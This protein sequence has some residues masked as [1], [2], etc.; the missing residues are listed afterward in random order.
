MAASAD[1]ISR[2]RALLSIATPLGKDALIPVSLR[3][4]EAISLPF[5]FTVEMVSE[6]E[7][8]DP[9]ALLAK[10][11]CVTLR[12]R[13]DAEGDRLLRHFSGLVRRFAATGVKGRTLWGYRA[14]IVPALWFLS[15]TE[16]CRVFQNMTALD[17]IEQVLGDGGV[18]E[19]DIRVQGE[20]PTREYTV[21]YNETDLAFVTRLMEEEGYF[22]FFE[23]KDNAHTLVIAN[24]NTAFA[25]IPESAMR[26]SPDGQGLVDCLTA[27]EPAKS[28]AHGRVRLT[29]YDHTAPGKALDASTSTVFS[30]AQA[31]RR[32]VT[33]WPAG[34][35][36]PQEVN[37]RVRRRI[38]AAEA[39]ASLIAGKGGHGGFVPGGKFNVTESGAR[40][41][42]YVVRGVTHR[43]RDESW[44][45]GGQKQSYENDF[46]AFPAATAW[47][48]R[49]SVPRPRMDGIYSGKVIGVPGE[50][51]YTDKYGRVKVRLM[52]DA[53]PD[54]TADGA[55]WVRVMQAWTANTWGWHFLPRVGTE[56]AVGFMDGDPDRPVVLGGLFNGNDMPV[57]PLPDQKTKSGLRTR[58]SPGG[59]TEDFSEFSFE[60]KKGQELVFLHAQKDH[61]VE[62]E[63]D[64][65]IHVMHDRTEK[66]DNN[67]TV[68][69]Q[70]DRSVT[71]A[72]GNES[73]KVQAGNRSVEVAQGNNALKVDMG[74]HSVGVSMGNI[75]VKADLGSI[76]LEAMQSITLKVG[77]NSVTI[78]QEGVTVK[79]LMV[80]VEGQTQ[81]SVKG[82][83]TQ[84]QG[85]AMTQVN[86]GIIMIG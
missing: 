21:Q 34:T 69:I 53:R 62:V 44:V 74:N 50:E 75:S 4:E 49:L 18:T 2:D 10:P 66:V 33:R 36:D 16:D 84:V 23:H 78:S 57:F 85:S 24:A 61:A 32:D 70:Q 60:D 20:K 27:W 41:G 80:S 46:T 82:L 64:Q 17:I 25:V 56:V 8:I 77:M 7:T 3:G 48:D 68:T 19:Y 72:Q 65:S 71:V 9:D 67:E 86:G 83:M 54:A 13:H 14:E 51:I 81:T 22:Y 26:V 42:E 58:S 45:A 38:E 30:T 52:W 73:L 76:T 29:D 15:Q 35:T 63:N 28:V 6:R 40:D 79:G 1:S 31:A 11:A 47:R 37:A 43:A 55:I 59:G 12:R 5:A 39:A